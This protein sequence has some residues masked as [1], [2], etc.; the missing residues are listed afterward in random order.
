ML[1]NGC[2]VSE[3]LADVDLDAAD[4]FSI[5]VDDSVVVADDINITEADI[6]IPDDAGNI[7]DDGSPDE[8]VD[9]VPVDILKGKLVGGGGDWP[10]PIS[11]VQFVSGSQKGT[12]DK[13]GS[14]NYEAGGDIIF[15]VGTV[16]FKSTPGAAL[17]SPWQLVVKGDCHHSA[18][19][20][21]AVVLLFSLD[22]DDD[23]SNGVHISDITTA[24]SM[25]PFSG[26]KDSDIA[27]L[28]DEWIPGRKP[29]DEA[30][31]V[32]T[33]V[34]QMDSETWA[35]TGMDTWS[36]I[37]AERRSQG[38]ATDGTYWY[39]SWQL[40][41][42]K[43]DLTYNEIMKNNLAIPPLLQAAGSNH[44]G[45]IDVWNSILY[46]PVEDGSGYKAPKIVLYDLELNSGKIYDLSNTLLT[47]GVP[48]VAVNGPANN[49]YVAEW[50]PTP[51]LYIYD[52]ATVTYIKTL[53][54]IPA[55]GRIQGAK[56]FEGAL[57]AN[58]DTEA[59]TT[60]KIDL[61]TGINQVV[62]TIPITSEFEGLAF[63]GLPDGSMMHTLNVTAS[64]TGIEF[65]HHKRTRDPLRKQICK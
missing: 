15:S 24:G 3:D 37:T 58:T 7:N 32:S 45:D 42:G 60:N 4:D 62:S 35:Q 44:I 28:I 27:P 11:G 23:P 56:M 29:I 48:W 64:T 46:A 61:E 40:G 6:I 26:I 12:T 53:P 63:L 52:L 49:L 22:D 10:G 55:L 17:I 36:D 33:F 51:G 59:K 34:R 13:D 65:R 25:E 2:A 16:E 20:A 54:L 8:D 31:A 43:T 30:L 18:D 57:Y 14:F 5:A 47:K 39:F 21:R 19:V 38:V 1:L 41:L 9:T 50:D